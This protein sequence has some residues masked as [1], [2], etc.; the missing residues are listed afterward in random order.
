MDL[1]G[2]TGENAEPYFT[3]ADILPKLNHLLSK[4][5]VLVKQSTSRLLGTS[6]SNSGDLSLAHNNLANYTCGVL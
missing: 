2:M 1:E 5:E 6:L 3:F 4:L